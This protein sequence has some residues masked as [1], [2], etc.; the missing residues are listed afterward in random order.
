MRIILVKHCQE[1]SHLRTG[2]PPLSEEGWEEAKALKLPLGQEERIRA[3]GSSV[4]ARC[5][6]TAAAL[7]ESFRTA[8]CI[9]PLQGVTDRRN[10]MPDGTLVA[11]DGTEVE[12]SGFL[13]LQQS[14]IQ[15]LE[16]FACNFFAPGEDFSAVVVTHRT[17]IA[18]VLAFLEGIKTEEEIGRYMGEH[19]NELAQP[20]I[21]NVEEGGEGSVYLRK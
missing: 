18:A 14:A 1:M 7:V 19:Y 16:E 12:P 2:D 21:I 5:L 8:E 15:T 4:A 17:V 6:Q 20:Q 11:A 10:R 9:E 13:E 3:I